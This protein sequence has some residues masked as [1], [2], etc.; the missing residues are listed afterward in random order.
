MPKDEGAVWVEAAR[1]EA[2]DGE[3]LKITVAADGLVRCA[4]VDP[5]AQRL[6]P[7]ALFTLAVLVGAAGGVA[8]WQEMPLTGWT[9]VAAAP[10]LILV[11][12][13][14]R[15]RSVVK[16]SLGGSA[17]LQRGGARGVMPRG[18]AK[19][20]LEERAPSRYALTL[21]LPRTPLAF[22]VTLAPDDG[23]RLARVLEAWNPA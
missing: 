18:R 22:V 6:L 10:F 13:L 9:V 14:V 1:A 20:T 5:F 12:L 3:R 16:L 8:V 15:S 2:G 17:S 11:G 23:Q 19:V 21:E 7:R 4:I